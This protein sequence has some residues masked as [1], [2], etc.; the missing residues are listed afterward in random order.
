MEDPHGG[1]LQRDSLIGLNAYWKQKRFYYDG[2]NNI[3]YLCFHYIGDAPTTDSNW[4]IW[5]ITYTGSNITLIE[6]P[7][8][9]I[10]DNRATLGWL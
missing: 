8:L 9:G 6:G 7:L 10:C 5:K 2:S 1:T 3:E 4:S